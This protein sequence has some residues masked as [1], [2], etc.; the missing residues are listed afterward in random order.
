MTSLALAAPTIA[1]RGL[2]AGIVLVRARRVRAAGVRRRRARRRRPGRPHV[3]ARRGPV[4]ARH[5]RRRA[6][7]RPGADPAR[8][9]RVP[10][11]ARR[12]RLAVRR[13]APVLRDR[14]R[15]LPSRGAARSG[16]PGCSP[17]APGPSGRRC[18]WW[19]AT[20]RPWPPPGRRTPPGS[21]RPRSR[22]RARATYPAVGRCRC[23]TAAS[24]SASWSSRSA[25]RSP[26]TSV[27]ERLFAGLATQAGLVLR[28]A[29]LRAELERRLAELSA[30]AEELRRLPAAA[31]R[32][33]GR[34]APAPRARHPRRRAAAPGRAGGEPAAR[35]R[36]CRERS[37]ERADAL[38]AGQEQAAADG[39]RHPGPAV[40]R[41]LP[42]LLADR[43]L[44]AALRAAVG[45]STVPVE[46]TSSTSGGTPSTSRRRRTS[47]AWR[48]C[49]TPPS[50]R[51]R[52]RSGSS[53]AASRGAG[54]RRRGRRR[55]L[56]PDTPPAGTGLAN[57]RDRVE[58]VGGTL[59]I[60][61]APGGGTRVQ[62]WLPAG[63]PTAPTGGG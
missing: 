5:G 4:R 22:A 55:R 54:L 34:R 62:A 56:R 11:G 19:W 59:T 30:R 14:D 49:R 47:A 42:A 3:V 29:R 35:R 7:L 31:G 41:H 53:C 18:G 36:R 37:P 32:R 2:A 20:G 28:G 44:A 21:P 26:L 6:G 45:T 33:P 38:L 10:G 51:A 13:A 24:C 15:E 46:I 17:T 61:S 48:R 27:E 8:G 50:T 52:P 58:S 60:E 23:A 16:W 57:M 12:P 43:G 25:S 63:L 9:A 40:P 1:P 39:R